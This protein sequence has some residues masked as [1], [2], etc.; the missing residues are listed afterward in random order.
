MRVL[1]TGGAGYVGSHTL[2]PLLRARHQVLVF[3]NFSNGSPEALRRVKQLSN[4]DFDVCAGDIRDAQKLEQAFG[5]FRP[6]AVIHLAGLKSVGESDRRPLEYYSQNVVGSIEL[7]KAMQRHH[8]R[9]IVFSSSATV[10][11]EARYLPCDEEHPTLPLKPYGRTK[12]FIEQIIRD[13]S[14]AEAGSSAVLLRY[15]N[16]AGADASGRIGE[17]PIGVP[18]NLVPY[19][20]Q[21]ATGR[22]ASLRIF[23]G[24][25]E[26]RDGTGERDFVHV[27]DLARAHVAAIDHVARSPGCEAINV[28]AGSGATVLEMVKAFERASGRPIPFTIAARREGDVSRSLA[29]ARKAESMLGW[30][31]ERDIADICETAWRWQ[32]GNPDGYGNRK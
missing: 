1:V 12:Y 28:G 30:K 31:A 14:S 22:L 26:T 2:L 29:A 9:K 16:P 17:D 11:G 19:I 13:W 21:V 18:A 8:C 27:E 10:Y 3:D 25:Y 7:L 20:A 32:S 4:A 6:D 5:E 23:G 15:F 24:D